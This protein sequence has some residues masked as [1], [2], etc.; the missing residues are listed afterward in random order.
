MPF[1]RTY[2]LC[3]FLLPFVLGA[4]SHEGA[5]PTLE[6][7]MSVAYLKANLE[8]KSPRLVLNRDIEKDLKKKLKDAEEDNAKKAEQLSSKS[9][10]IE[11]LELDLEQKS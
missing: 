2:L 7:P 4:Q 3:L 6:N 10:I 11:A 1:K 9:E 8:K 5:I